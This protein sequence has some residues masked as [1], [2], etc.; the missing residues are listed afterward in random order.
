MTGK[1]KHHCWLRFE[2]LVN[3]WRL[4][5]PFYI[6]AFIIL[7]LYFIIGGSS[8]E[9]GVT[10]PR[11]WVQKG[12]TE[13]Q[14]LTPVLLRDLFRCTHFMAVRFHR[15]NHWFSTSSTVAILSPRSRKRICSVFHS[16][17]DVDGHLDPFRQ[18]HLFGHFWICKSTLTRF[19]VVK[20]YHYTV[21]P[22]CDE[23]PQLWHI[24]PALNCSSMMHVVSGVAMLMT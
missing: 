14:K 22:V 11:I 10:F 23:F 5:S 19:T 17:V 16:V 13:V 6:L 20:H 15:Q 4:L 2:F 21:L 7:D 18:W 3:R 8:T 24:Q 12:V 1:C 9:K